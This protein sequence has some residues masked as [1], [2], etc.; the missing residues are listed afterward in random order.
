MSAS[1]PGCINAAYEMVPL[2]TL[3]P[4]PRNPRQGDVGAIVESIQA[5]QFY[6]ALVVQRSTR[7]ILAGNHRLIAA[8]QAGMTELPVLW[9]DCDD[10]R[11]LRILLADNRTNDLADYNPDALA[12][13]LKELAETPDALTGTGY[14]G[15]ALDELLADLAPPA[16][17][18]DAEPQIDKAEELRKKWGTEPGQ[19]WTLGDHRLLCGDSTKAE[20]VARVMGGAGRGSA[21][22]IHHTA[23][24]TPAEAGVPESRKS[25][26][27]T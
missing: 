20:D 22:L 21:S 14:D 6:G 2:A 25:K 17:D 18:V 10:D 26:T 7:H 3:K 15:D 16:S 23:S 1:K 8:K 12:V 5:N 24:G 9:V 19:L 13:L 27:T 11:A 4:H